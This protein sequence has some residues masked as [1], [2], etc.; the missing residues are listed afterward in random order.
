MLS[1][2]DSFLTL[3]Y[4]CALHTSQLQGHRSGIRLTTHNKSKEASAS[5]IP[6][7]SRSPDSGLRLWLAPALSPVLTITRAC[8]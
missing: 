7:G 5:G 8:L 3:L 6:G 1:L 2:Y 4:P